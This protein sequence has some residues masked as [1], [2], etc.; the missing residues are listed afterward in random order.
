ML[1]LNKTNK[2]VQI[3][4]NYKEIYIYDIYTDMYI[5]IYT[6]KIMYSIYIGMRRFHQQV[7]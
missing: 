3:S 6:Y 4:Q 2:L 5:Y 1:T 7:Q